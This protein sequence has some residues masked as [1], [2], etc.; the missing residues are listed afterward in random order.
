VRGLVQRAALAARRLGDGACGH[1]GGVGDR[2]EE[3]QEADRS[4]HVRPLPV[5]RALSHLPRS[6]GWTRSAWFIT[7]D[8]SIVVYFSD[9]L[10]VMYLGR[11]V[12]TGNREQVF[13]RPRAAGAGASAGGESRT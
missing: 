3:T 1:V 2:L 8:L 10:V 5:L 9:R 11:V 7:H 13:T 12:E 4:A 6:P